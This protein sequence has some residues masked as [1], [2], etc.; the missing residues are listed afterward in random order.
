MYKFI[1]ANSCVLLLRTPYTPPGTPWVPAVAMGDSAAGM[2]P[3]FK[4]AAT[5]RD[6]GGR[7]PLGFAWRSHP[8]FT[9]AT[10]II[11]LFSETFLYGII[12]PILPFLLETRIGIPH[13]D[14]QSYSSALLAA[15]TGTT[16]ICSPLAGALADRCQ[17]RKVPFMAGLAILIAVC[18]E[19]IN[20][21]EGQNT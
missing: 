13:K 1:L 3:G 5:N 2:P 15:Y 7:Q 19:H 16:V 6:E 10:V 20:P 17:S 14:L 12:I 18:L 21:R 4:T 8:L 11:G 9:V